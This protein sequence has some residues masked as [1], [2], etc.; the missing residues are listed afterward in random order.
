[1]VLNYCDD[2]IW[3]SPDNSLIEDYVG[4]LQALK[5]E[6]TLEPRGDKQEGT[7]FGFL[8]INFKQVGS[9]IEL[10]QAGL[11]DKVITYTGMDGAST[12]DTPAATAPLGS[13]KDGEP[14]DEEWS[15][16]AAVGM[17]LYISSNTRPDIQFAVHQVARF[18]HSPRKSHAQAVKR[19]VR[20]LIKT[21]AAE[22]V[23]QMIVP[24]WRSS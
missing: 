1:M 7:I 11:I 16:P 10:T 19:I 20:Y 23:R 15:M 2:Q 17:L 21:R 14:F 22:I 6:L 18:T 4:R 9:T 3:L 5:Y 24:Q 12:K 8:G 13:D